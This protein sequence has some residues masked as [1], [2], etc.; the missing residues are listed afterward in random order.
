[1]HINSFLGVVDQKVHLSTQAAMP[2]SSVL[3]SVVFK[4]QRESYK[5]K[6][7][8]HRQKRFNIIKGIYFKQGTLNCIEMKTNHSDVYWTVLVAQL[9]SHKHTPS[10]VWWLR[11][12]CNIFSSHRSLNMFEFFISR[13]E[14]LNSCVYSILNLSK[15]NRIQCQYRNNR[16]VYVLRFKYFCIIYVWNIVFL[17]WQTSD[18]PALCHLL[19]VVAFWKKNRL[20]HLRYGVPEFSQPRHGT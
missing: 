19:V 6:I 16:T 4:S 12:L 7:R 13:L 3:C 10:S 14:A 9:Y 15:S 11:Y 1:M 2:C 17:F 5:C 20:L 8:K 18:Y